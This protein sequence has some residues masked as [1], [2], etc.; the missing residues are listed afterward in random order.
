MGVA[1][2]GAAVVGVAVVGAAVV[3]VVVMGVVVVGV[4]VVGTALVGAAV[5]GPCV[6]I[7]HVITF[8]LLSHT[9]S[10]CPSSMNHCGPT[11]SPV[12]TY[13]ET[14]PS[15]NQLPPLHN[16]PLQLG[17][18]ENMIVPGPVCSAVTVV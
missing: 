4:A 3:G 12:A 11:A 2:V 7:G 10:V 17:T 14:A 15:A 13:G 9:Q 8:G 1:A 5:V 16:C 18:H 6:T